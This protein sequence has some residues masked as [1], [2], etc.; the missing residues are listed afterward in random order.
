MYFSLL[1]I[2][3]PIFLHCWQERFVCL[4]KILRKS[5]RRPP[6]PHCN[7]LIINYINL[8][9]IQVSN[10]LILQFIPS[11]LILSFNYSFVFPDISP[12]FM[13]Y[14]V[15]FDNPTCERCLEEDES[16][17]HILCDCETIAYFTFRHLGQFF[18]EPSDFYEAPINK[19]L[20]FIRSVG[21]IKG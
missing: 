20:R 10:I 7:K 6:C 19:V 18:M 17:T 14:T 11:S 15:Q 3:N 9:S 12:S 13:S 21:L 8:N 1:N 5:A 2:I 16:A 4:F